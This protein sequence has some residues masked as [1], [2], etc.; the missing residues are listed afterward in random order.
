M[1]YLRQ[2]R[3]HKTVNTGGSTSQHEKVFFLLADLEGVPVNG[4]LTLLM[5]LVLVLSD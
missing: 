1:N 3:R 2:I 4:A 5:P